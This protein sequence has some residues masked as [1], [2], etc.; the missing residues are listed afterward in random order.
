[1]HAEEVVTN[2]RSSKMKASPASF[3]KPWCLFQFTT[4]GMPEASMEMEGMGMLF[5]LDLVS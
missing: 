1:M 4:T 3:A 2:E 5:S